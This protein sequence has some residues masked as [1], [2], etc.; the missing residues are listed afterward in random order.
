M[1][2]QHHPG[3]DGAALRKPLFFIYCAS[4]FGLA[5]RPN[6]PHRKWFQLFTCI[7][8]CCPSVLYPTA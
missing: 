3:L 7:I 1:V 4:I 2:K 8:N 5:V 6:N